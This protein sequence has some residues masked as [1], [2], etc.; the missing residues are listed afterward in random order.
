MEAAE[1]GMEMLKLC[2]KLHPG[3]SVERG[4]ILLSMATML[5]QILSQAE[6][7]YFPRF[8]PAARSGGRSRSHFV[9]RRQSVNKLQISHL[10][11]LY[12]E[13]AQSK[14]V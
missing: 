1:H 8:L 13:S 9:S 2:D 14:D 7:T 5:Q 6:W 11:V 10:E 4:T 3:L 12:A